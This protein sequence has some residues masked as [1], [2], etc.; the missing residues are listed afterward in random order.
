MKSLN[1]YMTLDEKELL[2]KAYSKY[3]RESTEAHRSKTRF[4][5]ELVNDRASNVEKWMPYVRVGLKKNGATGSVS[6][7]WSFYEYKQLMGVALDN[8][9]PVARMVSAIYRSWL[10]EQQSGL[11][12]VVPDEKEAPLPPVEKT[13]SL[14]KDGKAPISLEK[15]RG[16]PVTIT[17]ESDTTTLVVEIKDKISRS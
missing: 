1:I 2:H 4:F 6:G 17:I 10:A 11:L 15:K 13:D 12:K 16:E 9:I 14:E 5:A 7:S 8:G 3:L